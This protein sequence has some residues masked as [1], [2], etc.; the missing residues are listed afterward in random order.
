MCGRMTLT[1]S[2]L[3]RVADE[4]AATLEPAAA[5][6]YRPR[7]NIAP[8]DQ[9][10]VVVAVP[11]GRLIVPARW[12]F[13]EGKPLI[14]AR[15]ET[16]ARRGPLGRAFAERRCVVPA[17]GFYEWTGPKSAR[18]PLWFHRADGGLIYL[19]GL[20]APGADGQPAFTVLTTEANELIAKVHD[21]MPVLLAPAAAADWLARP[22]QELLVP[23]PESL[24]VVQAVSPRVNSVRNDDPA[25]L[26]EQ[27]GQ[28][29]LL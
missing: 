16:A 13:G 12:G 19:A 28:L 4:L 27:A 9:H 24:L 2:S 5:A 6:L 17:D 25:L 18:Q 1:E 7:Y 11:S 21:R 14:N 8:S 23:A 3:A 15:S 22:A 26:V 20:W 10:W 29:D